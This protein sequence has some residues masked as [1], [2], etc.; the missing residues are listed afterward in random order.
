MAVHLRFA[1]NPP[2]VQINGLENVVTEVFNIENY[3]DGMT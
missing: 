3:D 1:W 2:V